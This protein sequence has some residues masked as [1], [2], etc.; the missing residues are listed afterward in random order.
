M[1]TLIALRVACVVGELVMLAVVWKVLHWPFPASTCLGLVAASA[2]M[3]L[4]LSLSPAARREAK[5]WETGAQLAFDLV[6]M[7]A[8][9][10]LTGGLANP[11]ALLIIAPVTVSGRALPPREAVAFCL[12]AI[13]AAVILAFAAHAPWAPGAAAS[14]FQAYRT[15]RLVAMLIAIVFTTGYASWSSA[16]TARREL[17]LNI[18]E[19]VLARE[20]RLS[21]LGALAAAAAH[22]LGTPLATIAIVATELAREAPEGPM[23]DDAEL[24]VEQAKR[25]RDILKRLAETPERRDAVHERLSLLQF[26]REI[27]EPHAGH[28]EVRVEALVTG[29]PGIAAPDL[30]RRPEMIHAISAFVENA[31]DFARSEI[32]LTARFDVDYVAIEVRDDG[33]GFS[34]AIMARLGEP[35]VTSRPGAEGSRTGHV[36]M[37]LGFFIAKTLLERTG[38]RVSFSNGARGG[39]I[40]TARWPRAAVEASS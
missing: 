23:R 13:S 7:T 24:L 16:E 12:L 25:C 20:Q 5:S 37:G 29:P 34:P 2:A 35:Y 8:L 39:A 22:E 3:N 18:T 15:A 36:G 26:V 30:W 4:A 28:R 33:P 40:V 38:A 19:T 1:R 31:F 17:A 10:A 9:I 21:A 6:Q 14:D 27:I 32:L 11:F